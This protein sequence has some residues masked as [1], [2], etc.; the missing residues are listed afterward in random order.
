MSPNL[1]NAPT[2]TRHDDGR[3]TVDRFTTR[4]IVTK[5]L[6]KGADERFL[7]RDGLRLRIRCDNADAEYLIEAEHMDD[8]EARLTSC[9]Y[10]EDVPGHMP[11][12][13]E[14]RDASERREASAK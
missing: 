8:V 10:Y 12:T 9:T 5:E 6:I 1:H 14:R 2:F 11:M 7:K 13:L 4:I 3:I